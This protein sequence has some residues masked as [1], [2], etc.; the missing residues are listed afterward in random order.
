MIW[1][2]IAVLLCIALAAAYVARAAWRTWRPKPGGCAGGC[3]CATAN[4]SVAQETLIPA[5]ELKVRRPDRI[6]GDN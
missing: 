1:Q 4:K 5:D 2:W 6:G 3:G